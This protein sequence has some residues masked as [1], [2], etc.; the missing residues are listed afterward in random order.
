MLDFLTIE[1]MRNPFLAALIMAAV[2]VPLGIYVHLRRIIFVG[3]A[4]PQTAALGAVVG[5][6]LGWPTFWPALLFA[7][8]S[9][10]LLAP[11]SRA[12]QISRGA[13]LALFYILAITVSLLLLA[14]NPSAET[15]VANVFFGN[16]LTVG[17]NDILLALAVAVPV[18]AILLLLN[19]RIAFSLFDHDSAEV[20]GARPR[21]S[22]FVFYLLLG[23]SV[24]LSMRMLGVLLTFALLALPALFGLLWAK[25]MWQ[26]LVAGLLLALACLYL[27]FGLSYDLDWP[28]GPAAVA[29]LVAITFVAVV[30]KAV[31]GKGT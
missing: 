15:E 28:T 2:L 23:L 10:V 29:P 17:M 22:E 11:L 26:A 24:A 27:G 5:A 1:F 6:V 18:L 30:V 3:I 4:A 13:I 21:L 25:R 7:W 9:I 8:V 19:R 31:F 16:V 12:R 20:S 14:S